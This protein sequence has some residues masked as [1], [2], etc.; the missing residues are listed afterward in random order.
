MNQCI[1][2]SA[3]GAEAGLISIDQALS[4]ILE[5]VHG[6]APESIALSDALNRYLADDVYSSMNLPLF[7]QSAVDGYAIAATGH[8][9]TQ[10]QFELVGELRAG[11]S[12]DI[13]LKE[14]QAVRI[15]TGAAIP[16]HTTT[17]ARQEIVQL[18]H[19]A[20]VITEDLAP[21]SDIRDIGE[22]LASG[23]QLAKQGQQLSVGAIA[24]LSMAGVKT[25]Q[26]YRYPRV[27]VVIT[28]DEVASQASDLVTGQIFDAN[29]PLINAWFEARQQ[30]VSIFHVA[31]HEE[32]LT[33]LFHQ[34][35]DEY[36][37][38]ISTG[39]VSVGDYD[40][41]RPVSLKVGFEQI[42]WK[43]KQKPGKPMLFAAYHNQNSHHC[44]L[45]GLPGNPAAVYVGMQIYASTLLN[46]LQNQR[47][48]PNW[49]SGKMTHTLKPDAR[50]R[51]LR[52]SA[53]FDQGELQLQS[54]SKQQSHM[55]TNLM[56]ANCLVR[57]PANQ[58]IQIGQC[59]TGIFI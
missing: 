39:G 15:F 26:V 28:G 31:D 16:K 13:D 2:H 7:S 52:M 38:I 8:I 22:E 36:D 30:K 40:F 21:H 53:Q 57:V 3:C 12:A 59:L 35:K 34:L 47:H 37:L 6:L 56:H 24:A 5:K 10:T 48:L 49:F 18:S 54:L 14:G 44:Y 58:S 43:I 50:E 41:V 9:S 11:Q 27:A 19:N 4:F 46:A 32:A 20:I 42:F 17:V 29:A 45:L 51:F 23:Q 1:K 25:V 55:L 33:E